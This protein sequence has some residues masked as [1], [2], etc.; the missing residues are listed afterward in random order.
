[1]LGH[2]G[3]GVGHRVN[4][5]FGR[6]GCELCDGQVDAVDPAMIRMPL[7]IPIPLL[8][9]H[10]RYPIDRPVDAP[11]M[12]H[13]AVESKAVKLTALGEHYRRLAVKGLI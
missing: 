9:L 10:R 12:W 6:G 8:I 3:Q 7:D 1:M 5:H 13:A 4:L 2:R 11:H